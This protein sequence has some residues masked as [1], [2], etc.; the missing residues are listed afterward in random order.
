M[1]QI[2]NGVGLEFVNLGHNLNRILEECFVWTL[3]LHLHLHIFKKKRHVR[4]IFLGGAKQCFLVPK[5]DLT[6]NYS[7]LPQLS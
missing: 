3:Q 5:H 1:L 2:N 7:F 6:R 4:Q